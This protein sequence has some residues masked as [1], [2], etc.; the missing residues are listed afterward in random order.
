MRP[1]AALRRVRRLWCGLI[2]HSFEDVHFANG[3]LH[4][5]RRCRLLVG[6][7]PPAGEQLRSGQQAL[8]HS[9]SATFG[10]PRGSLSASRGATALVQAWLQN[11]PDAWQAVVLDTDPVRLGALLEELTRLAGMLALMQARPAAGTDTAL[12]WLAAQREDEAEQWA[13]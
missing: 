4:A 3:C 5:C 10:A 1:P 13:P 8:A 2:E 9:G 11:D 12:R 7:L 6:A